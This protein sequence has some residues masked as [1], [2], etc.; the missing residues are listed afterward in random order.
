MCLICNALLPSELPGRY[1]LMKCPRGKCTDRPADF[2][3]F[4][5][6]LKVHGKKWLK[7]REN[8]TS[9]TSR[10]ITVGEG[11][12]KGP[13]GGSF[14]GSHGFQRDLRGTIFANRIKA[15]RV[16]HRQ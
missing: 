9:H 10:I 12:G 5:T 16:G 7:R 11:G 13:V 3:Q 14:G 4:R 15:G 8:E 6:I 1:R 2:E